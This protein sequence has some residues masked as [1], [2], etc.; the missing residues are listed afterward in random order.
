M[1]GYA[2][3]RPGVGAAVVEGLSG[4]GEDEEADVDVAEHSELVG[5][6]EQAGAALAEGDLA[7]D[8]VVDPLDLRPPAAHPAPATW[9]RTVGAS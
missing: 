5:L 3:C 9:K 7:A 6:L 8:G 2:R 4:V 1:D